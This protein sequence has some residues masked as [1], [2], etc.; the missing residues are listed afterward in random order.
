[1]P[2]SVNEGG[3]RVRLGAGGVTV[4]TT[5]IET[6][7]A[8]AALTVISALYVPA[9]NAPVV[10]VAVIDPLPVPEEEEIASQETFSLADQVR[11]PPPVLE[12]LRVC[13]LELLS[14]CTAVKDRVA[15]LVRIIGG[16]GAASTVRLTGMI[17]AAAPTALTVIAVL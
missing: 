2:V 1:M 4:K 11:I 14:P 9:I 3:L 6:G 12:M 10:A 5:G 8:L 16:R 13:E 15:G 7:V 17:T